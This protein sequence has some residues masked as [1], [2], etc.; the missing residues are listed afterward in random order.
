M[1]IPIHHSI[2]NTF[3]EQKT[4]LKERTKRL[5]LLVYSVLLLCLLPFMLVGCTKASSKQK[6][7]KIA[8]VHYK[9]KGWGY[10]IYIKERLLIDQDVMPALSGGNAFPCKEAAHK[11]ALLVVSRLHGDD[12]PTVSFQ[13]VTEIL[14][15]YCP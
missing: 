1:K 9:G 7:V 3:I 10:K 8:L 12:F 11:T 2:D 14:E 5:S 15:T 4:A 6:G 13:E